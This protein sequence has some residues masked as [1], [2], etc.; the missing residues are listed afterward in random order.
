MFRRPHHP[1]LRGKY[2]CSYLGPEDHDRRILHNFIQYLT[3]LVIDSNK[4]T[5]YFTDDT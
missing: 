4:Q 2:G 1:H 3:M 5:F